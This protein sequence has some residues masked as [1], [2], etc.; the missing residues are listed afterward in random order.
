VQ[1]NEAHRPRPMGFLMSPHPTN[2]HALSVIDASRRLHIAFTLREG[3]HTKIRVILARD[4]HRR[5]SAV[6]EK[7][8]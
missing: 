6:Y 2:W 4:M 5:E 1:R 3:G 8:Q 7:A